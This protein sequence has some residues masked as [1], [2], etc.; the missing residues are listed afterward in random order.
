MK[1][2]DVPG[3]WLFRYREKWW[4]R[5]ESPSNPMWTAK[6]YNIG[7]QGQLPPPIHIPLDTEVEPESWFDKQDYEK[8]WGVSRG[9]KLQQTALMWRDLKEKDG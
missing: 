2:A 9:F 4:L 8:R 1:L 7:P 5:V 3:G 6:V